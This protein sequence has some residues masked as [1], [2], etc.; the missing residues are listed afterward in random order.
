M[1]A[2][3]E[4]ILRKLCYYGSLAPSVHNTQPWEFTLRDDAIIIKLSEERLLVA[5]DPVGRQTWISIG[6]CVESILVAAEN[7]NLKGAVSLENQVVTITF[8][9]SQVTPVIPK[10]VIEQRFTDRSPYTSE[11]L[12]P[13]VLTTIKDCWDSKTTLVKVL[14]DREKIQKISRFTAKAIAMAL[15]SP[16]FRNELSELIVRP[17][18]KKRVGIPTN[19]LRLSGPRAYTEKVLVRKGHGTAKHSEEEYKVWASS[20]ALVLVFTQGDSIKFWLEAGRAYQ[21]AGLTACFMGLRTATSAAAVEALDFH[22]DIEAMFQTKFRLQTVMRIGKSPS[23]VVASPRLGVEDL[24][25]K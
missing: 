19:S 5:G 16:D 20:S 8:T 12:D 9:S 7:E 17:G 6:A 4:E 10:S 1:K 21:R 2:T 13:N 3:S 25:A 23:N 14:D 24:L 11:Q 15:S 22:E 18:D